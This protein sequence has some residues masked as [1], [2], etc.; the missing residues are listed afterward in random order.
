MLYQVKIGKLLN[1][2]TQE[3]KSMLSCVCIALGIN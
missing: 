2:E 1:L 3:S